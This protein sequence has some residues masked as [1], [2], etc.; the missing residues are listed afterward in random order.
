MSPYADP[1]GR[2]MSTGT[3]D[4]R[5]ERPNAR[6]PASAEPTGDVRLRGL[7]VRDAEDLLGRVELDQ[8]AR[9]ARA[10]EVEEAGVLRHPRG[11]LHVVG[12]DHDRVLR[13]ELVDQVLD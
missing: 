3:R 4:T 11:L 5:T 9:L 7:F 13:L 6:T 8:P 1:P 10:R 12:H 2:P